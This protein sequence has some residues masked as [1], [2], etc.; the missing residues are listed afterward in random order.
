MTEQP[1]E[2][3]SDTGESA[4]EGAGQVQGGEQHFGGLGPAEA[5]RRRWAKQREREA[6][7]LAT[8]GG[9]V[10]DSEGYVRVPVDKGAVIEKLRKDAEKGSVQAARELRAWLEEAEE[11]GDELALHTWPVERRGLLRA[12]LM[13]EESIA[14]WV[15]E[16]KDAANKDIP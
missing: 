9:L 10:A 12:F 15:N 7:G 5:A 6:Q 14:Q 11:E 8:P 1:P 3:T 2:S 13:H 4:E 16:K